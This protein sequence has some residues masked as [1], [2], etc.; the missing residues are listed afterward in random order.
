MQEEADAQ[1]FMYQHSHAALAT[2]DQQGT[3]F[4]SALNVLPDHEGRLIMLVSE[5][6]EHSRNLRGAPRASLVW[7]EQ[8]H[9]D[10]Q[11]A[12]R[13]TVSGEVIEIPADQGERYL[14]VFPHARDY[15]ALD[16][17]FL[18]LRPTSARW[19]PGFGKAAWLNSEALVQPWGWDLAREQAM[20]G[21]MND[22]HAD[23][24]DHY[25]S[26]LG[27]PGQ[28][29]RML[30]IDPWGAWLWH[31]ERLRRLPFPARAEDAGQ[32]RETLVM[33]ARTRPEDFFLARP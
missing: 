12:M 5:L 9:S 18:A 23:A 1:S 8:Q 27:A 33:L 10:W 16:F 14:Q 19:I 3:P 25:L 17:R 26:L 31:D 13:L 4:A 2:V 32:V 22:D 6:A 15:L 29:A 21:H 30:A 24:V 20:V 28:G 11:A 7:V